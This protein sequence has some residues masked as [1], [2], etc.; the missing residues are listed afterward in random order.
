MKKEKLTPEQISQK[1]EDQAAQICAAIK[2]FMVRNNVKKSELAN[3]MGIARQN[4]SGLLDP[5]NKTKLHSLLMIQISLEQLT[6]VTFKTPRFLS[7]TT[8]E[9]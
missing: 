8:P 2:A 9:Q 4:V 7:P 6:G 1:A 5:R 3:A